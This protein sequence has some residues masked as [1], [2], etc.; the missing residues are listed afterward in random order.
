MD[1]DRGEYV[2]NLPKGEESVTEMIEE[3]RAKVEQVSLSCN[4]GKF[5]RADRQARLL[6]YRLALAEKQMDRRL[7]LARQRNAQVG[8]VKEILASANREFMICVTSLMAVTPLPPKAQSIVIALEGL[9]QT[10]SSLE[11]LPPTETKI[12]PGT[13]A[14]EMGRHAYLNWAVGKMIH[15]DSKD[16]TLESAESLMEQGGGQEGLDKLSRAVGA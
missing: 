4:V 11:T 5:L 8:F 7:D 1:F 14:W 9:H 16:D 10:V 6:S 13:K 12:P 3:L 15:P 2:A